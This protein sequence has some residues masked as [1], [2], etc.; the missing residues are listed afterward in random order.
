MVTTSWVSTN[1]MASHSG[2]SLQASPTWCKCCQ[3]WA[4]RSIVLIR[5]KFDPW[6]G[7]LALSLVRKHRLWETFLVDRLGFGWEQVHDI[8]EQLEHVDSV[9]LVERLDAYLGHPQTDPHGDPIPKLMG[10]FILKTTVFL[11]QRDW[12]SRGAKSKRFGTGATRRL[13]AMKKR[14]RIGKCADSPPQIEAR[15]RRVVGAID[16]TIDKTH[17]MDAID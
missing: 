8:A 2:S 10:R 12:P 3:N 6:R 14:H 13:S 17:A 4:G 11:W 7:K 15:C 5:G 9:E 1:E 16:G